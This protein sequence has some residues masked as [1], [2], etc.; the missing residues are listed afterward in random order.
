MNVSF[1]TQSVQVV[2]AGQKSSRGTVLPDWDNPIFTA[3]YS[4]CFVH[5]TASGFDQDGRRAVS[6]S[7]DALLPA[8]ADVEEGDHVVFDGKTYTAVGVRK[9]PFPF[10]NS[11]TAH[12]RVT[13]EEWRG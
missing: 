9:A 5:E 10:A 6:N 8:D 7:Y 3:D 2:R 12:V 11:K 1:A 13:I 4:G